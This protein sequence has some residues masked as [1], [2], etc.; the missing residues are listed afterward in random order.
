MTTPYTRLDMANITIDP[1]LCKRLDKAIYSSTPAPEMA[2]ARANLYRTEM[3]DYIVNHSEF[4]REWTANHCLFFLF[5]LASRIK[6]DEGAH[7]CERMNANASM[8]H[9][10]LKAWDK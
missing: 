2:I 9:T 10:Q 7:I 4:T 3:V 8:A 5:S 1:E 6:L